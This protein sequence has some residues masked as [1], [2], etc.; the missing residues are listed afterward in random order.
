MYHDNSLIPKYK[1]FLND[2]FLNVK[3]ITNIITSDYVI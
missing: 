2:E 1:K 3:N